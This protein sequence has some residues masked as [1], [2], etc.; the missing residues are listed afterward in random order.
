M[1]AELQEELLGSVNALAESVSCAPADASDG[2][3]GDARELA[4]RLDELSG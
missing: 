4:D 3:A 2:A 1:P